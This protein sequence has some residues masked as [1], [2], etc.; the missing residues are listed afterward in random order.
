MPFV[1]IEVSILIIA[2][3]P[4]LF[5]SH[6]STCSFYA[7]LFQYDCFVGLKFV[8]SSIASLYYINSRIFY[9]I[10]T[11]KHGIWS[12]GTPVRH[13]RSMLRLHAR[14]TPSTVSA[15]PI[16][17]RIYSDPMDDDKMQSLIAP[18]VLKSGTASETQR[19]SDTTTLWCGSC[20]SDRP[21]SIIVEA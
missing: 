3:H 12:H 19:T 6:C 11:N 18:I 15:S 21:R 5:R 10:V 13:T 14:K 9:Q 4:Q 7:L 16:S 2:Y 20:E 17:G 1:D 8:Q